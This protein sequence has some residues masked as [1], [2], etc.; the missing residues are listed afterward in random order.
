MITGPFGLRWAERLVP[1]VETGEIGYQDPPSAYRIR[2]WM[3]L[4]PRIGNDIFIK[5]YAQRRPGAEFRGSAAPGRAR[6]AVYA[7]GGSMWRR[8]P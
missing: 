8:R 7:T 4:A 1:R 5:L 2:R 3:E 6:P